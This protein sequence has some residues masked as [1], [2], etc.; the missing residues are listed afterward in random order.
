[1]E[2]K[3]A[4]DS[5]TQSISVSW[6]LKVAANVSTTGPHGTFVRPITVARIPQI[7][8]SPSLST[9]SHPA[10]KGIFG[11]SAAMGSYFMMGPDIDIVAANAPP[12]V[13]VI[14]PDAN[15]IGAGGFANETFAI[16]YTLFDVDN[17]FNDT[18]AA[19]VAGDTLMA[20]LYAYPDN[21]LSSVQDIKT[22]A[23]LIVDQRD[24]NTSTAR[25]ATDPPGTGDFVE[26]SSS[27]NKQA[28]VWD[29][30][31]SAAQTA[32]GWAPITKNLDGNYYIYI[33]GDDGVNPAVFAVSSGALRIRHIPIIR[34][35]A[36][37]AADT[38]DTGEYSNLAKANPYKI[39][40]FAVDYD[41]NAQLRLF[42]STSSSLAPSAV[43]VTGTFP[44]LTLALEGATEIQLSDT[45]RTD[46][47][48]DF[49]FDVT[50]QGAARDSV[51]V[52]GNYFI[53]L[54]RPTRIPSR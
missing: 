48:I 8:A 39:K 2:G 33:V 27:G 10:A 51:I 14:S 20:E 37:V 42:L 40:L 15:T 52:Q 38:V 19:G 44:N 26:G 54:W 1:L 21:G 29:N 16:E 25:L 17:S 45:L 43:T 23:T 24:D 6:A 3:V 35:V 22:F 32:F 18:Y 41:D 50:A 13:S 12:S 28:Y 30:P 53:Y 7:A 31:G 46:E 47:D 49:D 34:S 9:V 11:R 36:P 4:A 5:S